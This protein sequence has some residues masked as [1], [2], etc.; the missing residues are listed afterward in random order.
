MAYRAP[1]LF[2]VKTGT[3][4]DEKVDMWS[5]GCV[6]YALAYSHS[7]FENV[8]TTERGGSV[9]MAVMNA[10][11]AHPK[12]GKGYSQGLRELI[13]CMLVVDPAKRADIHQ[14]SWINSGCVR[15]EFDVCFAGPRENG[16]LVPLTL[17]TACLSSHNPPKLCR[18]D[19]LFMDTM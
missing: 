19:L 18:F 8:D 1:E 7:P 13:D 2:D 17:V 6:L 11:Y 16:R 12:D 10:R 15:A 4:L 14:V 9:A 5:L 3:T